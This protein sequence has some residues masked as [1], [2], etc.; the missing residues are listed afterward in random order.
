MRK[1]TPD[2]L[3]FAIQSKTMTQRQLSTLTGI[4]ETKL[5]RVLTGKI[6]TLTEAEIELLRVA[7]SRHSEKTIETAT[8][9]L[10]ITMSNKEML[11]HLD[12]YFT[13]SDTEFNII[14]SDCV[15]FESSGNTF[16]IDNGI[17]S[18]SDGAMFKFED[19]NQLINKYV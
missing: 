9:L 10:L 19:V 16:T 3:R 4:C 6:K 18:V 8:T 14:E 2:F 1:T 17:I 7:I 13:E 12:Y 11:I 15:K 5:N